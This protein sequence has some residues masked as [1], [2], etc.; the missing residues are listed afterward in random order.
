[1][2]IALGAIA[3]IA[4]AAL[5][6]FLDLLIEGRGAW[7]RRTI[8]ANVELWQS[9]PDEIQ[10]GAGGTSLREHIDASLLDFSSRGE[11]DSTGGAD[12]DEMA[13]RREFRRDVWRVETIIQ[14]TLVLL[15]LT[16]LAV[17]FAVSG[18]E[19]ST[20]LESGKQFVIVLL[21]GTA[22][23]ISVMAAARFA[24]RAFVKRRWKKAGRRLPS[25]V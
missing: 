5:L 4:G 9:L 15:A 22:G 10:T 3:G 6:K 18:V 25:N 12:F 17:S 19:K 23:A 11:G 8:R 21:A 2:W 16:Y 7:G 1:M 14:A 20:N 24:A 13:R